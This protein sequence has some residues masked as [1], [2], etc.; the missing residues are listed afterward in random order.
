MA[1][2]RIGTLEKTEL[3]EDPERRVART[4]TERRDDLER[5]RNS[6]QRFALSL[7]SEL[8]THPDVD[9]LPLEVVTPLVE[10]AAA[11]VVETVGAASVKGAM[12][13][14]TR[15]ASYLQ[16][17]KGERRRCKVW[18][19]PEVRSREDKISFDETRGGGERTRGSSQSSVLRTSGWRWR[20]R[21]LS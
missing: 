21:R 1:R 5:E 8:L 20:G 6:S 15:R 11:A 13:A 19:E 3:E 2:A 7:L 17:R 18:G 4:E 14:S 12:G 9:P 10:A 16:A